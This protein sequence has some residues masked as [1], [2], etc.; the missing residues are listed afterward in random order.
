LYRIPVQTMRGPN[1][2]TATGIIGAD[3]RPNWQERPAR[4]SITGVQWR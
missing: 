1:A 2:G 4:K 3:V